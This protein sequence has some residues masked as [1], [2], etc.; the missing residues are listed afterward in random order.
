MTE[1]AISDGH[2][3]ADDEQPA[4]DEFAT[5]ALSAIVP[6]LTN[7]RTHF[8]EAKLAEL[9]ESIKAQGV[10]QPILV[11]PLPANRL[12][13]TSRK[14]GRG[15]R[16]THEIISG[17]R[18]YRASK[19]AGKTTIPVLIR[20]WDDVQVLT[21]QLVE[22]LQRDDL[23]ELEEAEGYQRL[24][25]QADMAKEVIGERIGKS[26]SYV[27][28]RL[29]LLD[30][31]PAGREALRKG[32]IDFSKALLIA[33]VPD[34]KLQIKALGQATGS[35]NYGRA[36]P[37]KDLQAWLQTNVM[38]S[39]KRTS[40]DI[41]DVTLREGAGACPECPKRTG[42]NPDLFA[43]VDS[44]DL[45][46]DPSCYHDKEKAAADR[47]FEAA[48]AEGKKVIEQ[49]KAEKIFDAGS[50][51]WLKGYYLLDEYPDYRL[52]LDGTTLRRALGKHCPQAVLVKHPETGD[53]AKVLP[54][55]QVKRLIDMHGLS[56]TAKH[57]AR[58]AAKEGKAVDKAA[59]LPVE[60]RREY[61][62][63]WQAAVLQRTDGFLKTQSALPGE[64]LRAWLVDQI[65]GYE[66]GAFGPALDLGDE[67][68]EREAL[69][70]VEAMEEADLPRLMLR[71]LLWSSED[72]YDAWDE[73]NRNRQGPRTTLFELIHLAGVDVEEAQAEVKRAMESEDRAAELEAEKAS[74]ATAPA[75]QAKGSARGK[76]SASK[77]AAPAK[78]PKTSEAEARGGIAAALQAAEGTDQAP[79][80]AEQEEAAAPAAARLSPVAAWPFPT[81]E[82][83]SEPVAEPAMPAHVFHPGDLAQVKAG[84]K[85]PNGKLLKIIGKV[86]RIVGVGEDG[87]LHLRHGERSHELVV[88]QPEHAEPYL[89]D[90]LIGSKVRVLSAVQ[91]QWR[92]GVVKACTPDGWAVTLTGKAGAAADVGVFETNELEV[93]E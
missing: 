1:F 28:Q 76:K 53:V 3:L 73:D 63:R 87:R 92:H 33:R 46:T 32:E 55:D 20:K 68:N 88:L 15:Q 9:A 19:L 11:R 56:R 51:N 67:F 39:L 60:Q 57:Q 69:R 42:A 12:D 80:G 70:R 31:D 49:A 21:F 14:L 37:V 48:Q 24:I 16:E 47:R 74:A 43:D 8:D 62:E 91:Y 90:P 7:P 82:V 44:A 64:L 18:R 36:L 5:L 75:A 77:P 89:A 52:E 4:G 40:F 71:Y 29:K 22:N 34:A 66:S 85:G 6:S 35:D 79:D 83:P 38:L 59:P 26:R 13:E 10:G 45:C 50:R 25:D 65:H 30:L 27:Y 58:M 17:E 84:S 78:K 86:G 61:S 23:S 93:L 41:K 54:V 81:G 72:E 2:A